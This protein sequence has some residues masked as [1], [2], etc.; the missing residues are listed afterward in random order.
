[1]NIGV[2]AVGNVLDINCWSNTPFYFYKAGKK[3][4]LFNQP[5]QL[6]TKKLFIPRLIWNILQFIKCRQIRGFQYTHTF[7]DIAEKQIPDEYFASIV[8]SFNQLFPRAKTVISKQGRIFYYIDTTLYDLFNSESYQVNI[9]ENI[10]KRALEIENSNYHAAEA[11]VTMS[12]WIR[13]TLLNY[14][15]IPDKKLYTILPGANLDYN[16]INKDFCM[17]LSHYD[18][19]L[20][21][22]GKDWKRKGLPVLIDVKNILAKRG[23]NV[24]VKIIGNCPNQYLSEKNVIYTGFLDKN[25]HQQKFVSEVKSCDIGCLFSSSEALGISILEFIALGVPVAG[26]FHQGLIDTLFEDISFRFPLNTNPLQIADEFEKFIID[27]S[28]KNRIRS[29][30]IN[31]R[32]MVSWERCIKDWEKILNPF[33]QD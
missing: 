21:F 13:D 26:Y 17:S 28:F 4:K 6:N 11:I 2:A 33:I 27:E 29:N 1:M 12:S 14:Y 9:S 16:I 3:A 22:I 30:L 5:W 23:Y 7:L 8:I 20:G 25:Y 24:A 32:F 18:L 19:V 15:H 10:K 31:Y